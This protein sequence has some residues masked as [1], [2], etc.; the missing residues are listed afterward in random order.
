MR[1]QSRQL[2]T[3]HRAASHTYGTAVSWN[4]GMASACGVLAPRVGEKW[5]ITKSA[6]WMHAYSD[7]YSF[8]G[9]QGCV[10]AHE[11][12]IQIKLRK[13]ACTSLE[14]ISV[15]SGCQDFFASPLPRASQL[16]LP[17]SRAK[18]RVWMGSY[19]FTRAT[20]LEGRKGKG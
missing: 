4:G 15:S 11:C 16:P 12:D 7:E 3:S 17:E 13:Y 19:S 5:Y 2:E 8:E 9:G 10:D 14:D 20:G 18:N 6:V 1:R